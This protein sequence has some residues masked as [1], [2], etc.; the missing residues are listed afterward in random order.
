M[1]PATAVQLVICIDFAC[2]LWRV[3]QWMNLLVIHA[4]VRAVKVWFIVSETV[5]CDLLVS[6]DW[7]CLKFLKTFEDIWESVLTLYC[8]SSAQANPV[9]LSCTRDSPMQSNRTDGS[10]ADNIRQVQLPLNILHICHKSFC[11]NMSF[12]KLNAISAKKYWETSV[13]V[14]VWTP[15][16]DQLRHIWK[17]FPK[18]EMLI[19]L[20][21][22]ES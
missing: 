4:D 2:F 11:S 10:L 3:E 8:S 14:S 21:D 9:R 18:L 5:G 17:W 7:S 6:G 20:S 1:T 16:P 15:A 12:N 22:V 13:H 19:N